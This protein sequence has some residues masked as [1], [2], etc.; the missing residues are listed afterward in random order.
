[1]GIKKTT[2]LKVSFW[3]FL[4]M[5]LIGLIGSVAVPFS[6]IFVGTSMGFITYA[7]YSERSTKNLIPVIAATP[8]LTDVQ[9]PMGCKYLLLDKNYQIVETSLEGDDLDRAIDYAI[10][11]RINE[12]LSKQYLLVTRE[13]EY[14]VLQYYI[15]SQFTNDWVYDHFPSPEI[16]L[17]VLIGLNCI[18]V[19]VILTTKFAKNMRAQ[20]SPLF[21]ATEQVAQ[22]NLDFEM[23]H[24]KIKEFEDVLH[25]FSDMKDTL[26][27][28][29]E[30][31]WSAEQLQREQIA[32]LA[33]DLK[34]PLTVIQGNID[35]ISETELNDEQRLYAEYI[36]ESSQQIGVYIKTLIDISRTVAGYQLHLE[37]FDIADYM[38]RIEAQARFLCLSKRICLHMRTGMDLG[39]LKADELLLERAIMNVIDNA[40]DYSPPEGTVYVAVQKEDSFIQISITDEGNGFMPEALYHAQEQFFM[41]DNSRTSNLHFGM[42][43]YITNSII[44]QHNGQLI[45]KNSDKTNGAQVIIKIPY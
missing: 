37:E 40:L 7:D 41:G 10:S 2:S 36:T 6:L 26:K 15:G 29:L 31:Q 24:S 44:K 5:L 27:S 1:M 43:L 17:Y 34:T 12:S 23:G 25:S 32:A 20:L 42:G 4:C 18:A 14:V 45:L 19:C 3:E 13:N 21:E 28:S 39:T 33:H 11:G 30:K 35:L 8:D 9:L 22:Q 16:L 38:K